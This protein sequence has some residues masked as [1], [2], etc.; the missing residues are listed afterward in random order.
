MSAKAD[1]ADGQASLHNADAA[2]SEAARDVTWEVLSQ[3]INDLIVLADTDGR[4]FYVSP[5]CRRLGYAQREMVGRTAA[6]FVHPDDLVHVEA[7]AA[8]LFAGARAP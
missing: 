2:P 4:I 3:N 6:D 1:R 7:G 8:A 5:S